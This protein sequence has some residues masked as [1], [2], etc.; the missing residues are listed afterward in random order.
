M[1]TGA[2]G[3]GSPWPSRRAEPRDY[4]IPNLLLI[5]VDPPDPLGAGHKLIKKVKMINICNRTSYPPARMRWGSWSNGTTGMACIAA[6]RSK[7][8]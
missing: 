6:R 2:I 3:K 7:A 5:H 1:I 8:P 4:T